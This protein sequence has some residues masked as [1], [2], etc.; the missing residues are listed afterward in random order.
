MLWLI[1]TVS[2]IADLQNIIKQSLNNAILFVTNWRFV[3]IGRHNVGS[4]SGVRLP[5]RKPTP[6]L[7]WE[8]CSQL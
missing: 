7:G 1:Y 6:V 4:L 5:T 3:G 2:I 8:R